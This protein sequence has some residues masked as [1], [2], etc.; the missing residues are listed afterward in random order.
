MGG[1]GCKIET[2]SCDPPG[3]RSGL[4]KWAP[5]PAVPVDT[6]ETFEC[7]CLMCPRNLSSGP[8][9][10][11]WAMQW[12]PVLNMCVPPAIGADPSKDT[13]DPSCLSPDDITGPADISDA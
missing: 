6:F 2:G 8:G 13:S 7:W 12:L 3:K 4:A 11:D 9:S 5:F 1:G 10:E